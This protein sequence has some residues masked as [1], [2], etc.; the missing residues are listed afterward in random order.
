MLMSSLYQVIMMQIYSE[1]EKNSIH[2]NLMWRS[3]DNVAPNKY[4]LFCR[5]QLHYFNYRNS[6]DFGVF[7]GFLTVLS[8]ESVL[9]TMACTNRSNTPASAY[10]RYAETIL[11]VDYFYR[12]SPEDENSL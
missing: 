6:I 5:G 2:D 10:K 3:V 8:I 11:Y 1:S 12:D 9:E 7:I 4:L